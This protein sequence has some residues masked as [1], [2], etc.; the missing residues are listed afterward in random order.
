MKQSF[1]IIAASFCMLL[2]SFAAFAQNIV[3][4]TVLDANGQPVMGAAVMSADGKIGTVSD[5]DGKFTF[6]MGDSPVVIKVSCLGYVAM[7]TTVQPK[8]GTVNVTL[9]EDSFTLDETVVVGYGTQKKSDL[10]GALSVVDAKQL[11]DRSSLDVAHMLQG[12]V[13]G[14]TVTSSTGRPGQAADLNIRGWNSINGGSPLVLVDG[15]EGDL[16]KVSASDVESISVIKDAAAAAVYGARASF[17]VILVTTKS[18]GDTG[19]GKP[20]VSYSGRFGFTLPTTS[21]EYETRGYYSVMLN[22]KFFG[23]YDPGLYAHYS[24]DDIEELW[25]RR[26]DVTENPERPWVTV[27]MKDGKEVYNYYANTDWYHYLYNDL[28]PTQSHSLTVSGG[29]KMV[30]YH[31][32]GNFNQEQGMFRINPDV[33]KKYALRSKLSANIT[34]WLNISNNTSFF[35]SIYSYPG[36]SGVNSTFASMHGHALASYPTQNPDGTYPYM[37]QYNTYTIMDGRNISVANPNFQNADR[38]NNISN[39]VELTL[40]PIK[41]LEIK[42]NYTYTFYHKST[43][44]RS[45]NG[46]HSQYPGVVSTLDTGIYEDKLSEGYNTHKY[47]AVNLYGTYTDTFADAHNLK[48]M[49]G[50]NYETKH[51]KDLGVQGWDLMSETMNDMNLVAESLQSKSS[52]DGDTFDVMEARY[53]VSGGQNEYATAGF[54]GR[55]NYDYKGKYLLE[56]AGRYDGTSRFQ[57]DHRW[58]FF[59]SGSVGWKISDENFFKPVKDAWNLLK[60]R[61]S[62]GRLGNQQV[63]YYDYIRTVSLSKQSYLFGGDKPIGASIASPNASDLTWETIEQHNVGVDMAFLNNRLTF[64]G[65]AYIRDTK[66]MLSAGIALPA[67]YGADSPKMNTADLRTK[68]YELQIGWRDQVK[69]GRHPLEY[70]VSLNFNDYVSHITKFDNPEKAFAKK[71]WVGMKAGEIWGYHIEGLFASDE[72]AAARNVDQSIVNTIINQ[73]SGDL[74]LK[75][76]DMIFADLN[77]NGKIDE[78]ENTVDNPGDRLIIGNSLPRFQYGINIGLRYFGFDFAIFLQGVGKQ[79]WYPYREASSFWGPYNRPYETLIPRNFLDDCWSPE[80][81][82]AY[83]PRPRGY[84]A[85]QYNRELG[86]FNDRYIQNIAYCRVKNVTFGYTL[87]SKILD[88]IKMKD[89]RIYFTGE[90]L[91]YLAPGLHSKYVDPEQA[92]SSGS[93]DITT[94]NASSTSTNGN[95]RLR[96]YPWQKTFM[97]G[98]DISF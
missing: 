67:V 78:G 2:F 93:Q 86:A 75:A 48:I 96:T 90:N 74:G 65:E 79:D 98:I 11:K 7:E 50:F 33:Y 58:G 45:V 63:G 77:N 91:G 32:S 30:K 21:T 71:Y 36:E 92:S 44:N 9:E 5:L 62:Y 31:I 15:V 55:I 13:P 56:I 60:I 23:T 87:P 69:L 66:N 97:F 59:P 73:S 29:T 43:M 42:G 12:A 54:F 84:V 46:E 85:L 16:Q 28:K 64:T 68:G 35:S 61:Y 52:V 57:Q 38:V 80:N 94:A 10:T 1:R 20:I 82:N 24:E 40:T 37:T 17:G 26:N 41:Q 53:K 81:P 49:L 3:T 6:K 34:K 8:Q 22:N 76:G 47:H 39:T 70:N 51:L 89:L 18:G 88:R 14:L 27:S 95:A 4:G 72:E 25:A 83:F 19:D